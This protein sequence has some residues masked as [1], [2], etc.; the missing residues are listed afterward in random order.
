LVHRVQGP[1]LVVLLLLLWVHC[2][3]GLPHWLQLLLLLLL[4]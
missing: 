3:P 4:L 2:L 1:C